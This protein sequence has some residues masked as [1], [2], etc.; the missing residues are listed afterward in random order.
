MAPGIVEI[1]GAPIQSP[2]APSTSKLQNASCRSE[3]RAVGGQANTGPAGAAAP[4][5]GRSQRKAAAS[6]ARGAAV[7]RVTC[8]PEH[9]PARSVGIR[10]EHFEPGEVIFEEGGH[11]DWLSIIV[12]GEVEVFKRVPGAS[13]MSLRRLGPGECFGEIALLDDHVRAATTRNVTA[14]NLR[15]SIARR[16]RD[17]VLDP[18]A[19][20][21]FFEDRHR[22]SP[23][24]VRRRRR[25]HLAG[26]MGAGSAAP[27]LAESRT[28]EPAHGGRTEEDL[29]RLAGKQQTVLAAAASMVNPSKEV[30]QQE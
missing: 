27:G 4:V 18:A 16:S 11:G 6:T 8:H 20:R 3:S 25:V 9:E 7:M 24:R 19:L 13:E 14:V 10:R 15:P 21:N 26:P 17:A 2:M 1:D 29:A 28:R 23:P 22:V 30:G 5:D 12:D